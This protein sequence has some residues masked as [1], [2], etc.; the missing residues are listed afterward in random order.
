M[1]ARFPA[2]LLA[3]VVLQACDASYPA[4]PVPA[5]VSR[6]ASE[7]E[8]GIR[9]IDRFDIDL[10]AHGPLRPGQPIRVSARV[11]AGLPT[12]GAR[13]DLTLP[14]LEVERHI[15]KSG[16]RPAAG[17]RLDAAAEWEGSLRAQ[18]AIEVGTVI[19]IPEPGY[20]RVVATAS[21]PGAERFHEPG[22]GPAI[23]DV[24]VEELWLLVDEKGGAIHG[25]RRLAELPLDVERAPG[26]FR[27]RGMGYRAPDSASLDTLQ[28]VAAMEPVPDFD[29]ARDLDPVSDLDP[30]ADLDP[31]PDLDPAQDPG[32]SPDLGPAPK[33][34][35]SLG[36]PS[37]PRGWLQGSPGSYNEIAVAVGYYHPL[38]RTFRQAA[39]VPVVA[40]V[41]RREA[42]GDRRVGGYEANTAINGGNI[43][44]CSPDDPN[45]YLVFRAELSSG[46][47]ALPGADPSDEVVA[48]N[49]ECG[50]E[51]FFLET[52]GPHTQVFLNLTRTAAAARSIFSASRPPVSVAID[53][54]PSVS[55]RYSPGT[56]GGERIT[57]A[58]VDVWD[59]YGTFVQAHEYGHAFHQR[60]WGGIVGS[61]SGSHQVDQPSS[62]QCAYSEG[63]ADFFSFATMPTTWMARNYSGVTA[64]YGTDR[65]T[66]EVYVAS[67]LTRL[68]DAAD[69]SRPWDRTH[70][71]GRYIGETIR[72]CTTN[73]VSPTRADGIDRLIY[74][75]ER[76]VDPIIRD[77]YFR[78]RAG[79]SRI[80]T[81]ESGVEPPAGWYRAFVRNAWEMV[82]YGQEWTYY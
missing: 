58:A 15:R 82:L 39:G 22:A 8:T 77:G 65:S 4:A 75:L 69:P 68:I 35:G 13:I 44:P 20:Y 81:Q 12:A 60:A 40:E 29:P 21:A 31:S 54:S 71:P 62:L 28:T 41:W 25:R 11:T 24:A 33:P 27:R 74:C 9:V 46:D 48:T 52:D 14:D 49:R 32:P 70:Y 64:A 67:F 23:R 79:A 10:S 17:V 59:E 76:G 7:P 57:I 37:N 63:I 61:C 2:L 36:S 16:R 43:F 56:M 78:S 47:V 72:T 38:E 51:F 55:S 53:G 6:Q 45:E 19:T 5:A 50:L 73:G 80:T 1:H 66:T 3:A 26:A 42:T 34:A 30:P 18:Q